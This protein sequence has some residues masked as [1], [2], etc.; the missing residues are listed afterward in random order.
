MK[1]NMIILIIFSVGFSQF[2]SER[3]QEIESLLIAPCCFG[4]VLAEHDYD[5]TVSLIKF[6]LINPIGTPF[7][8]L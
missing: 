2:K 5:K 4:G 7:T 1:L 6:P 3:Q 8:D